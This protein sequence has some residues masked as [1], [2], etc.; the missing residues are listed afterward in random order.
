MLT[1]IC[2]AVA[3]ICSYILIFI[4]GK[5]YRDK[6]IAR[7]ISISFVQL[8]IWCS[9]VLIQKLFTEAY[10]DSLIYF[11]YITYIGTCT[12]FP[13]LLYLSYSFKNEEKKAPKWYSLLF[14]IPCICLILLWTNDYHNLFYKVYSTNFSETEYGI[15]FYI[16]TIYSYSLALIFIVQMIRASISNSGFLSKQTVILIIGSLVPLVV[17]ILGTTK[18]INISIYV[19]PILFV[20]TL[21]C[22][23]LA[24]FKY[25]VLNITPI[26]LSTI[27]DTMT[28]S[29]IVISLDGMV[30][31]T[32]REFR[33]SVIKYI[34][35]KEKVNL[36]SVLKSSNIDDLVKLEGKI[37]ECIKENDTKVCEVN[38]FTKNGDDVIT[39]DIEKSFEI[40]ISLVKNKGKIK[41][42]VGV[43]LLI[44]D[45]T[46]HKKDMKE[47]EEK[48][49]IIAKQAQLVSIGELAGGVA[50]DIN[51]P[52]SAIR[53]GITMLKASNPERPEAEMQ[54]IE[55]MDNC[56]NKI[57]NIV[58][59]MRN[60]IRNLGGNTDTVFKISTVIND[61]K[62]IT[63]HEVRK[64]K[65]EVE[66]EIEDDL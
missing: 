8:I 60:Q 44:N 4:L 33:E 12:L 9:G 53:T 46:Q 57:L 7:I 51:T 26:A 39:E 27:I 61:I 59:S 63:Y 48:Q 31:D 52:I 32:N 56:S 13:T 30:V 37:K 45:I 65:A 1:E 11:D 49:E 16:N 42:N 18:I 66:V 38:I 2:L 43:L 20:I 64:Y 23:A 58:N 41:R 47:L 10:R 55:T 5:K 6:K 17:N 40:K 36:Y 34:D 24:I 19:T 62:C 54:I 3:I 14:I 35:V 50:H 15:V 25:K 28:D 29:F 21:M 22:Y